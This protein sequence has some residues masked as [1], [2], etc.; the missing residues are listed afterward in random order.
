MFYEIDNLPFC[1]NFKAEF[2][3]YKFVSTWWSCYPAWFENE[4]DDL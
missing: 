3:L 4:P 1:N 2:I